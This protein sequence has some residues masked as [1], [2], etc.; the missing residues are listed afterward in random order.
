M[1]LPPMKSDNPEDRKR[2]REIP[3]TDDTQKADEH[4]WREMLDNAFNTSTSD[5]SPRIRPDKVIMGKKLAANPDFP[6]KL[7]M[8]QLARILIEQ[9]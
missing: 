3:P 9:L 1:P 8:R 7:S 4:E 2:A 5:T 6:S